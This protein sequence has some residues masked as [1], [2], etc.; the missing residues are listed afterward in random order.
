VHRTDAGAINYSG[1]ANAEYDAALDTALAEPDPAARARLMRAAEAILVRDVPVL[2]IY[3]YVSRSLVGPRV[4]GWIDNPANVHP[5]R[6]LL[7]TEAE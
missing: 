5:S 1:Y 4:S 3:Y 6:T 7:L 2:P